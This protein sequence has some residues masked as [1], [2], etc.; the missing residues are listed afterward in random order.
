MSSMRQIGSVMSEKDSGV[1]VRS[2]IMEYPR[3]H[4]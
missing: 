2:L 4:A 3:P 1:S